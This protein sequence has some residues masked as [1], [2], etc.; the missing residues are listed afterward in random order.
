MIFKQ[1][2][3]DLTDI[4]TLVI[5]LFVLA[6]GL[7][8][9]MFVVPAITGGLKSAGL[10]NTQAGSDAVAGIDNLTS[11]INYGYLMLF[12]GLMLSVLISSFFIR[13]HPIFMFLYIFFLAISIMLSIYLGN[14]YYSLEQSPIFATMISQATF[15]HLV[16][17]HIAE[18]SLAVGALSIIIVF[19]KFST[20][21]GTQQF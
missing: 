19:A 12:V 5:T 1:K 20:Y 13:S 4:L 3:G 9:L 8:V 7:L 6:V 15:L 10:N 17:S 14:A 11:V 2:K 16:M 18:I 21:G